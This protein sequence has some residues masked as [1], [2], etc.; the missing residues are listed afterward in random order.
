MGFAQR[1]RPTY[2]GFPV[3]DGRVER[4][5]AAFFERKPHAWSRLV[6]CSR[7]SGQRWC[8]HGAPV[9]S[10]GTREGLEARPAAK[11]QKPQVPPLRY[12][13]VGMTIHGV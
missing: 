13:P 8:E 7:K 10:C 12:A 5:R 4:L 1:F 3:E 11:E 2:P 6:L 9:W